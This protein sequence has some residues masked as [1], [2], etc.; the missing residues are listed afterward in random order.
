MTRSYDQYCG[1]ARALDVIGDR[2]N[3][4][5]VRQLLVGSA[6]YGQLLDGLPGLA[7]NLLA[8]RLRDLETAGVIE[9][10]LANQ[11]NAIV[12]T[13]TPWGATLREPIEALIWWATPLMTRGPGSDSFRSEWLIVA[14]PALLAGTTTRRSTTIAV[15]VGDELI[16]VRVTRTG[17][18]VARH[19]GGDPDATIRAD[20]SIILGLAAGVLTTEQIA[21]HA[22]IEGDDGAIRTVFDEACRSIRR[23]S[24][25]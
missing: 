19:N 25:A 23:G 12:Y 3:L 20:A 17:V 10:Q 8:D 9:R 13:L 7:T 14:L 18:N 5:I 11:G 15:D 24:A 2:W 21:G 6:R 22:T 4:L 1:L 16:D